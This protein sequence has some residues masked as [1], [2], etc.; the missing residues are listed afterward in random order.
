MNCVHWSPGG[1]YLVELEVLRPIAT[2]RLIHLHIQAEGLIELSLAESHVEELTE[3]GHWSAGLVPECL[4]AAGGVV[5]L[6]GL[7]SLVAVPASQTVRATVSPRQLR[8][9]PGKCV[10]DG[11][12]NDE[13]VVDHDEETDH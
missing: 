13:V 9:E 5:A 7:L 4:L 8:G 2:H 1:F 6:H 10:V 11:P 3:V 12:G